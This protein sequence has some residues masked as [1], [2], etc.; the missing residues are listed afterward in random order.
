[1]KLT[2]ER[3]R[4]DDIY[5]HTDN[6]HLHLIFKSLNH[7]TQVDWNLND[8]IFT[9]DRTRMET[10]RDAL[11]EVFHD[12]DHEK[13]RNLF[14]GWPKDILEEWAVDHH[15][16]FHLEFDIF[17]SATTLDIAMSVS[18]FGYRST[19]FSSYYSSF[20]EAYTMHKLSSNL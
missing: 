17:Y 16:Y 7:P 19:D 1:M 18:A 8:D 6:D 5:T 14:D 10:T 20:H 13:M 15:N 12:I 2:G 3:E 9:Y 11:N 4:V